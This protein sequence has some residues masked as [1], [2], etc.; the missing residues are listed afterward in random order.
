MEPVINSVLEEILEQMAWEIGK[1]VEE[2]RL[3]KLIEQD[4]SSDV[5]DVDLRR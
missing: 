4:G 2:E 5:P 3:E 1:Q